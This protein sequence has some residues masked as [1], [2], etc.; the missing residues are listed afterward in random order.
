MYC[1]LEHND[2]AV[3]F[4]CQ[5][6]FQN[7]VG[8]FNHTSDGTCNC[9][10]LNKRL[11]V[12]RD[13]GNG[14]NRQC[15]RVKCTPFIF[16]GSSI[17]CLSTVPL[18]RKRGRGG[19]DKSQRSA[20]AC[21]DSSLESVRTCLE[22]VRKLEW[23][24]A[25]ESPSMKPIVFNFE[26]ER[27][28]E[29]LSLFVVK[30]FYFIGFADEHTGLLT[31]SVFGD[32]DGTYGSLQ[33]FLGLES[34]TCIMDSCQPF[35]IGFYLFERTDSSIEFQ[36]SILCQM[37]P[38]VV[39]LHKST[40]ADV[41][42]WYIITKNSI[43]VYFCSQ[44]PG[45]VVHSNGEQICQPSGSN[46]DV[47]FK[48]GMHS[49]AVVDPETL[50]E[51][52]VSRFSGRIQDREGSVM[53]PC[54]KK[55]MN[56]F[57]FSNFPTIASHD[58]VLVEAGDIYSFMHSCPS[59]SNSFEMVHV[60]CLLTNEEFNRL[61]KL[62]KA[63]YLRTMT[64]IFSRTGL[65]R[66]SWFMD[67]PFVVV[68]S[69]QSF[70]KHCMTAIVPKPDI[71]LN[72]FYGQAGN[73]G[74]P[75][76]SFVQRFIS[77]YK[78]IKLSAPDYRC[79]HKIAQKSSHPSAASVFQVQLYN[80]DDRCK[81]REYFGVFPLPTLEFY[82][83]SC[84]MES[85][86][87]CLFSIPAARLRM[88]STHSV[89][90]QCFKHLFDVML[91]YGPVSGNNLVPSLECMRCRLYPPPSCERTAPAVL[92]EDGYGGGIFESGADSVW[93]EVGSAIETLKRFLDFLELNYQFVGFGL[94][95]SR[96][97][98][99]SYCNIMENGFESDVLV[100]DFH[101]EVQ[102]E[103][104]DVVEINSKVCCV[105]VLYCNTAHTYS[106]VKALNGVWTVKDALV[107][108]FKTFSSF[109]DALT[110]AIRLHDIH[111]YGITQAIYIKKPL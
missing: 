19:E 8:K 91:D 93:G 78:S 37:A 108:A 24:P 54:I 105:A 103:V 104:E 52:R 34:V 86:V 31:A 26:A 50:R 17:E 71:F 100:V 85:A 96:D 66:D 106:V 97:V 10:I 30:S 72:T 67:A 16:T 73:T 11:D 25:T 27:R 64:F 39:D 63:T 21:L 43:P 40:L 51:T 56:E 77:S 47:V 4:S 42:N 101:P 35:F 75:D 79:A 22:S 98:V 69:H 53:V 18:E 109:R 3:L 57:E 107:Q 48:P 32:L 58:L 46:F 14:F 65:L 33:S 74:S 90:A 59:Q 6:E 89:P 94:L 1:V 87:N 36:I 92:G 83:N 95:E 76:H 81:F 55:N 99:G 68:C 62:H 44:K 38:V 45:F 12:K 5:V 28:A 7:W 88:Y 102:P 61:S 29:P 84:W 60:F 111:K 110:Y 80:D 49:V 20:T 23:L 2:R 70:M 9:C 15:S 82:N 13:N 41:A